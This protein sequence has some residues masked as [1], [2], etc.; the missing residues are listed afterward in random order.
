MQ[1]YSFTLR[2]ELISSTCL[3]SLSEQ[4]ENATLCIFTS[5]L[6]TEKSVQ[7]AP[8]KLACVSSWHLFRSPS[9]PSGL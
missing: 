7:L 5:G 2:S 4:F 3:I 1:S 9:E 6:N 8:M